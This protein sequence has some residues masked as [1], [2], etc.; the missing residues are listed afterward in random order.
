MTAAGRRAATLALL[1]G[2]VTGLLALLVAAAPAQATAGTIVVSQDGVDTWSR[3][4]A[5]A[6]PVATIA[7]AVR[8]AR[9]GDT[10]VVHG[11]T[12]P[13]PVGYGA[14]PA[15]ADA[16]ITLRNAPGERVVIRG[17]LQLENADHWTVDGIDVTA[18]PGRRTQFLV[19][20]DGGTGWSFVDSEVW[21]TRGVSN[22]MV[23]G[24]ALNGLPHDYRIANDC[25][26][27]NRATGD[28]F[29]N[30]H[31]I[32]LMPGSGS[33]PGTIEH[34]IVFGTP[35]GAAIKA[36][37]PSSST[38]AASRVRISRNT[39]VHNAAGVILGYGSNRV[40]LRRNLIGAQLIHPPK[41]S[42]WVANY[43]GAVIGNHLSGRG[44]AVLGTAIWG[45]DRV[46]HAT[47]DS[48]PPARKANERVSPRFSGGVSCGGLRPTTADTKGYGRY[49]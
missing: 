28:A 29:M 47:G 22:V 4:D 7:Q 45:Y 21:G 11:G 39:L 20:F 24:S 6:S 14:V 30:D 8:L 31:G 46:L 10:I 38:G 27:D 1:V 16:P 41:G 44:N 5:L 15:R 43:D 40:V 12:Y 19:K 17:T 33:G 26:H 25:I 37:G 34:N 3:Q 32:Y 2:A 35:N 13:G 23:T 18:A 49:S 36:A 48:R 9:P 42:R